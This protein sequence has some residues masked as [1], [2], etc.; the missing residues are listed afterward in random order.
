MRLLRVHSYKFVEYASEREAPRYG[1]LSH[2]WQDDE[3]S[4]S[5]VVDGQAQKKKGWTKI[6]TFCQRC[7]EDGLSLAWVD[8]CCIDKSSSAELSEAINSMYRWY[9]N[10]YKCYV[11]LA[12][13]TGPNMVA[14]RAQAG[15]SQ[16]EWLGSEWFE[17]GWALQELIAPSEVYMY[18]R[19][20]REIGNK[21]QLSGLISSV[22]RIPADVLHGENPSNY[23]I[24]QRM[25]WAANRKTTRAE[26]QAYCLMGLFE[27]NMPL[28][29]GEGTRAFRRLQEEIIRYSDDLSIFAW[30]GSISGYDQSELY[31][32]VYRRLEGLLAVSPL[33]FTMCGDVN[34]DSGGT[35]H[36][37]ARKPHFM[38]NMGLEIDLSLKVYNT[39]L[40]EAKLNCT[41]A[42]RSMSIFLRQTN[43]DGQYIRDVRA[44]SLTGDWY[45]SPGE[46]VERRVQVLQG[47]RPSIRPVTSTMLL[48]RN[49]DVFKHIL[50]YHGPFIHSG[51]NAIWALA[52]GHSSNANSVLSLSFKAGHFAERVL[53]LD[54]KFDFDFNPCM[55]FSSR[56][57]SSNLQQHHDHEVY[58][59]DDDKRAPQ[60]EY[61]RERKVLVESRAFGPKKV[62]YR[63]SRTSGFL[64]WLRHYNLLI[65]IQKQSILSDNFWTLEMQRADQSISHVL[66][67][68]C[69]DFC[70]A[71]LKLTK[72]SALDVYQNHTEPITDLDNCC[73]CQRLLAK[74]VIGVCKHV[75]CQVCVSWAGLSLTT[76]QLTQSVLDMQVPSNQGCCPI[77]LRAGKFAFD[78]SK[79]EELRKKYPISYRCIAWDF[80]TT[81]R[82]TFPAYECLILAI[83]NTHKITPLTT[84]YQ[85]DPGSVNNRHDWTFFVRPSNVDC[86]AEVKVHLHPTFRQS[87]IVLTA[88]P[89]EVRRFGWGTFVIGAEVTLKS[90]FRYLHDR[91]T[92]TNGGRSKL[93]LEWELSFDGDGAQGSLKVLVERSKNQ[94]SDNDRDMQEQ[95]KRLQALQSA[96][97]STHNSF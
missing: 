51:H 19:S 8:T 32:V 65:N 40:Y 81:T 18:D 91:A 23:C 22:T 89:Y 56:Y 77:C 20:W 55:E 52:L 15:R 68:D 87:E 63:A 6:R 33:A 94:L 13:V 25:S 72:T 58:A 35:S 64:L 69:V 1:I 45:D 97:Q 43:Q 59:S 62:S 39:E 14:T 24:A 95:I 76:C 86:V 31:D 34:W 88:E 4:Y 47:R 2:R 84:E 29:Y 16:P 41:Q 9:K 96:N 53:L 38:T 78:W 79:Q 36:E 85:H 61:F 42:G 82:D 28:L 30:P 44:N 37:R 70:F 66:V 49:E 11:F 21:R 48:V 54:L 3:V 57:S 12:D 93:Q 92:S 5:N 74:P 46:G 73:I 90:G 75:F 60:T 50:H 83:G 10:A 26:D 17:R 27:V 71:H 7:A 67:C 80:D